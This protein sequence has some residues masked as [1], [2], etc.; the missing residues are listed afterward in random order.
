MLASRYHTFN[1]TQ[2][3]HHERV[4]AKHALYMANFSFLANGDATRADITLH[5]PSQMPDSAVWS[6]SGGSNSPG[7]LSHTLFLPSPLLLWALVQRDSETSVR[8][9]VANHSNA[10]RKGKEN[11]TLGSE[12]VT[13]GI[14]ISFSRRRQDPSGDWAESPAHP[15]CRVPSRAADGD[16]KIRWSIRQKLAARPVNALPISV[17]C[18][19][20]GLH[21]NRQWIHPGTKKYKQC[22][23]LSAALKTHRKKTRDSRLATRDSKRGHDTAFSWYGREK[24]L[25]PG[26]ICL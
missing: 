2:S 8:S 4:D 21:R 1:P 13:M 11:Q 6:N 12:H 3:R 20:D 23:S 10:K 14:R 18:D 17:W 7:E 25:C 9:S 19:S 15:L 26:A 22:R 5:T 24:R 16:C